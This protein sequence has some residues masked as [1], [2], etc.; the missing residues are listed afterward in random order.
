[1][2]ADTVLTI[3]FRLHALSPTAFWDY[4]MA[5][6]AGSAMPRSRH[7]WQVADKRYLSETTLALLTRTSDQTEHHVVVAATLPA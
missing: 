4:Q 3:R 7:E 2:F 5:A 6:S 1:M